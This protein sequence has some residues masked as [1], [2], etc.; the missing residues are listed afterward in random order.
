ML[1]DDPNPRRV[2]EKRFQ[3]GE[4]YLAE[5]PNKNYEISLGANE[6]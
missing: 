1:F 3:Y 4:C 6:L 2:H 5:H